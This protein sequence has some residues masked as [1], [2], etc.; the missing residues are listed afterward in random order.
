MYFRES[1]LEC[2]SKKYEE[3]RRSFVYMRRD[4]KEHPS[5]REGWNGVS[6]GMWDT[7]EWG[8]YLGN[9]GLLN[10]AEEV[11]HKL[12]KGSSNLSVFDFT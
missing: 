9:N 6:P 8:E 5:W 7:E 11:L 3:A 1:M 12:G 2:G 4:N 10:E